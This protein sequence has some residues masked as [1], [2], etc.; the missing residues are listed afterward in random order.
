[1]KTKICYRRAT[2]GPLNRG[3]REYKTPYSI[4]AAQQLHRL[5][6]GHEIIILNEIQDDL[7]KLLQN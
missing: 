1:M 3:W 2:D 5:E 6:Q 7:R 4:A